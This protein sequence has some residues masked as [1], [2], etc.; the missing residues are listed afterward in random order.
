MDPVE[1][2]AINEEIIEV[3]NGMTLLER[4]YHDNKVG[5]HLMSL[6]DDYHWEVTY[7]SL[8]PIEIQALQ[9]AATTRNNIDNKIVMWIN[10]WNGFDFATNS[11]NEKS[12]LADETNFMIR[13][14]A[15]I[16]PDHPVTGRLQ[17]WIMQIYNRENRTFKYDAVCQ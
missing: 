9:A 12:C 4:I 1:F 6:L 10:S 13:A 15:E 16:I 8:T 5:L 3:I 14:I 2:N 17:R 7:T 11:D